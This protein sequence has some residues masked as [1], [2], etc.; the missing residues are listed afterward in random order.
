M[1][2][3]NINNYLDRTG[4]DNT[5]FLPSNPRI[6]LNDSSL[7]MNASKGYYERDQVQNTLKDPSYR[8]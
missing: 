5:L 6:D 2:G 8:E 4:F 1:E 7:Q 3:K